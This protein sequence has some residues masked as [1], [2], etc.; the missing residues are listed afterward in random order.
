MINFLSDLR[1]VGWIFSL[2]TSLSSINNTDRNDITEILLK[3]AL[4]TKN[5]QPS[6]LIECAV[7][8]YWNLIYYFCFRIHA[9]TSQ[10]NLLTFASEFDVEF[11]NQIDELLIYLYYIY[12]QSFSETLFPGDSTYFIIWQVSLVILRPLLCKPV[13]VF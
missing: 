10:T 3:V 4:N 8:S 9:N 11:S 7:S 2:R 6:T 13:Y 12:C 1:Q 5:H